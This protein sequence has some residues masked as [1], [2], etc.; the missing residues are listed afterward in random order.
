MGLNLDSE[1]IWASG[2]T[3]DTMDLKSIAH[4]G[5][6]GSIPSSPIA[7]VSKLGI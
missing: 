3:V 6:E 7:S 2:G 4:Y 1:L 5:C